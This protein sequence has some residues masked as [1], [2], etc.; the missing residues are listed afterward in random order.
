[1]SCHLEFLSVSEMI[2]HDSKSVEVSFCHMGSED[3]RQMAGTADST[4]PTVLSLWPRVFIFK[5]N[6]P[7]LLLVLMIVLL[8]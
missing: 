2:R 8:I 3:Q 4:L 6:L 1:M 7:G 5:F